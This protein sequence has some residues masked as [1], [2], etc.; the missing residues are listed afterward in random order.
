MIRTLVALFFWKKK[1][2]HRFSVLYSVVYTPVRAAVSNSTLMIL[3]QYVSLLYAVK[4]RMSCLRYAVENFECF[5]AR[6]TAWCSESNVSVVSDTLNENASATEKENYFAE[7]YDINS[8]I[9]EASTGITVFYKYYTILNVLFYILK[10]SVI[11]FL[12]IVK[13]IPLYSISLIGWYT[14][15]VFVSLSLSVNIRSEYQAIQTLMTKFYLSNKFKGF[16]LRVINME[17][18]STQCIQ[19]DKILDSAYLDVDFSVLAVLLNFL[20]LL[21]FSMLPSDK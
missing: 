7:I 13:K 2:V 21:F 11:L 6:R 16:D 10:M 8:C 3:T 17:K 19:E 14:F 12:Y 18:W 15:L 20:L 9:F 5:F 4:Q 1:Y